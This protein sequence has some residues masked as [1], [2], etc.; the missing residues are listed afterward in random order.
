MNRTIIKVKNED[1]DLALSNINE[2]SSNDFKE[3]YMGEFQ[4][5]F[6]LAHMFWTIMIDYM[7]TLSEPLTIQQENKPLTS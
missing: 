6:E 3:Y 5:D 2:N 1:M 4:P 7:Q